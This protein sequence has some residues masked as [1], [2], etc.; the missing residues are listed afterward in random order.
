MSPI[1]FVYGFPPKMQLDE[2]RA[3]FFQGIDESSYVAKIDFKS[4][5]IYAFIHTN[6]QE[7]AQELIDRW[8][9]KPMKQ[10]GENKL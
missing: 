5:K 6:T 2:F 10:S 4:E 3:E 1:V 7:Q 8:H 9:D